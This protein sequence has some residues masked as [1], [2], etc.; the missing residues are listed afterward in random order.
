MHH[1][2]ARKYTK[3]SLRFSFRLTRFLLGNPAAFFISRQDLFFSRSSPDGKTRAARFG[4]LVQ[5]QDRF[6]AVS[7]ALCFTKMR[8]NTQNIPCAFRLPAGFFSP[9]F[10]RLPFARHCELVRTLAWRFVLFFLFAKISLRNAPP[11]FFSPCRKED[12]PRPGQKKRAP[13]R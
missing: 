1:E 11:I 2:N 8:G 4:S 7:R 10:A 6:F 9:A 3:Y 12:G 5:K 13:T